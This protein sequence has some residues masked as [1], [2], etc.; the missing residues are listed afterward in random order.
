VGLLDVTWIV[1][2]AVGGNV[3]STLGDG[4]EGD[5]RVVGKMVVGIVVEVAIG[6][7][8]GE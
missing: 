8:E 5:G 6:N 4:A 7:I 3:Q 2:I 1:G